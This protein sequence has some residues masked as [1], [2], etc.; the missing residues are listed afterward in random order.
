M[1]KLNFEEMTNEQLV[2][3]NSKY[4]KMSILLAIATLIMIAIGNIPSILGEYYID[5]SFFKMSYIFFFIYT[6]RIYVKWR[7]TKRELKNRGL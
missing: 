5:N 6:Y 1:D 3:E 4:M 7:A 2:Q